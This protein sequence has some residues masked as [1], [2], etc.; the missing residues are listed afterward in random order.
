MESGWTEVSKA[1]RCRP[2]EPDRNA[3]KKTSKKTGKKKGPKASQRKEAQET[4]VPKTAPVQV[5]ELL[6]PRK[7]RETTR[8]P[9]VEQHGKASFS[10][11]EAAKGKSSSVPSALQPGQVVGSPLPTAGAL[12]VSTTSSTDV[13]SI[14]DSMTS[15][16]STPQTATPK[17]N[18]CVG[19]QQNIADPAWINAPLVAAKKPVGKEASHA[20]G[21]YPLTARPKPASSRA[22]PNP[23]APPFCPPTT[24]IN[25]VL[26][27]VGKHHTDGKHHNT[28]FRP[29]TAGRVYNKRRRC[30]STGHISTPSAELDF[31]PLPIW[32]FVLL[33]RT[34]PQLS[35]QT[36]VPRQPSRP[37]CPCQPSRQPSARGLP[38]MMDEL[39]DKMNNELGSLETPEP[40]LLMGPVVVDRAG[41]E[42][43]VAVPPDLEN[44]AIY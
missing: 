17:A 3:P 9:V 29:P 21:C 35:Q 44:N 37:S 19:L 24:S 33:S 11:A 12:V 28:E 2:R 26:H 30:F 43:V 8:Q 25:T 31:L 6:R 15:T 38:S 16:A 5:T 41:Y 27:T 42:Y 13:T 18:T 1:S 32:Y 39:V 20:A 40:P 4:Q 22:T 23:Q 34:F 36:T 7:Q 14:A 10:Y